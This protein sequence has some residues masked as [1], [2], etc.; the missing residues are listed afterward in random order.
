[1]GKYQLEVVDS[2]HCTQLFSFRIDFAHTIPN[3]FTPNDDGVNDQWRI[4]ILKYYPNAIVQ[5]Y[6]PGGVLV[7][8]SDPGYPVPWDG[9]NHGV[10]LPS[11]TYYY[12]ILN[13]DPEKPVTG[14]VTLLR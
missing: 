13:L 14:T 5:V 11:G 2:R 1:M 10:E 3:A 6:N 7:F 9:R 12:N 8:Q 4:D